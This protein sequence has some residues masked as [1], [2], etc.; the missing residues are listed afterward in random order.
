MQV[1]DAFGWFYHF[2]SLELEN[3]EEKQFNEFNIIDNEVLYS[4]YGVLSYQY[5][6]TE[7]HKL[8]KSDYYGSK[9]EIIQDDLV[10][11]KAYQYCDF[12]PVKSLE[13][14]VLV[15]VYEKS[16][17]EASLNLPESRKK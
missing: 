17:I 3:L 15:N 4:S 2:K 16:Y 9:F 12:L 6:N 5:K 11:E 14:V 7:L 8:M 1:S 10:C 13:G